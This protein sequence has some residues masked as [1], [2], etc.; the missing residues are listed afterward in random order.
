MLTIFVKH[1]MIIKLG[2]IMICDILLE[3]FYDN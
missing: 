2:D 3:S 1:V